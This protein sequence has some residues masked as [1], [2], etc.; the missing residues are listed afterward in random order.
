MSN[1]QTTTP[2]TVLRIASNNGPLVQIWLAANMATIPKNSIIQTNIAESAKEIT[3]E[4]NQITLRTSGDL[5]QGIVRVYSK[6]AGF[7]LNDI[8]DTLTKISSLFKLNQKLNVTISKVNTVARM[9]QLIL[10]DAVTER[11]VLVVP[12]LDFLNDVPQST[13]Q[14]LNMGGDSMDRKVQGAAAMNPFD[15]ADTSLEVGRRFDPDQDLEFNQGDSILNLDFDLDVD[16]TNGNSRNKSSWNEGTNE[17]GHSHDMHN[18]NMDWDLGINEDD[19]PGHESDNSVE[20]GRRA[21]SALHD[22]PTTDF[23]FDLDIE[24]DPIVD[25]HEL[26]QE[27]IPISTSQP[28]QPRKKKDP[29]L[30]NTGKIQIDNETEIDHQQHVN[31]TT[32]ITMRTEISTGG[33]HTN[34]SDSSNQSLKRVWSDMLNSMNYLPSSIT[35]DLLSYQNI[36]RQKLQFI[37]EEEQ[38]EEMVE[39]Q[40]DISLGLNDD[41]VENS[42]STSNHNSDNEESDHFV[43]MG[44]DELPMDNETPI[45]AHENSMISEDELRLQQIQSQKVKLVSGEMASK[46]TVNMAETLRTQYID[47]ESVKFEDVLSTLHST[48]NEK[49]ARPITKHEASRAF[50][51]I[52]SLATT[53]CVDLDQQETFGEIGISSNTLLFQKFIMS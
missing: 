32:N 35:E 47:T 17:D 13:E 14:W 36:K 43:G 40:M 18:D 26:S 2:H 20:V 24:K 42:S 21:D 44:S 41:L 10:E 51:D 37:E 49:S 33:T 29:A 19:Q 5:L 23:G 34:L 12:G 11:D 22:E 25:D 50:F 16:E 6:Q 30:S 53:G 9:D 31:D 1:S 27:E 38:Q 8:K 7:L 45:D 3:N 46:A 39:P 15:W 52:L 4:S 28:P 48:N